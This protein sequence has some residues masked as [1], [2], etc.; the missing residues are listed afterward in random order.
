MGAGQPPSPTPLRDPRKVTSPSTG[1]YRAKYSDTGCAPVPR[2]D[3]RWS[4]AC[5]GSTLSSDEGR[6][7]G[8]RTDGEATGNVDASTPITVGGL[9]GWFDDARSTERS[10]W[11]ARTDEDGDTTQD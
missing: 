9:T 6:T 2:R 4:R 10:T 3:A 8:S 1:R 5:T 11:S 7:E